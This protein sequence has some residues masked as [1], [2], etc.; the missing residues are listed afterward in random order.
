MVNPHLKRGNI[1]TFGNFQTFSVTVLLWRLIPQY[2]QNFLGTN[3]TNNRL[4]GKLA[5]QRL[6]HL[7]YIYADL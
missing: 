4:K 3:L 7:I 5:N 2:I 6:L 1:T